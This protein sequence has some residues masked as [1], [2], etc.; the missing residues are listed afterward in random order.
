MSP[1]AAG[2]EFPRSHGPSSVILAKA[3]DC[4]V[5]GAVFLHNRRR[6][7]YKYG[8]ADPRF[9]ELRPSNLVMATAIRKLAGQG[10]E[11]LHFGRTSVR[12]DG[13][14]R[15][16]E[17]WGAVETA[18][19][20]YRYDLRG[21]RWVTSSDRASGLHNHLFRHMPLCVNRALGALLYP[22]LD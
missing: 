6:A 1:P 19:D 17:G 16:K 22:H 21:S 14:R 7:I 3:G 18:I 8:A 4:P 5:A 2:R 20:Y 15:F 9:Q 10:V 12:N 11:S 13:L